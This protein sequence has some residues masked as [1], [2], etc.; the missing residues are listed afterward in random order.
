[1]N[2]HEE[3]SGAIDAIN[4]R[5]SITYKRSSGYSISADGTQIPSYVTTTILAQIQALHAQELKHLSDL[6]IAGVLRKLY[7]TG[8]ASSV[9]RKDSKGGDLVQFGGKTWKVVHVFETWSDWSSAALQ[10]QVD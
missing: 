7:I 2:L 10:L 1:M 5:I 3:I 4:P 9:V 6:N 8:D